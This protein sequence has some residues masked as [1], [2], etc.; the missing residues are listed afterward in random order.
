VGWF[1]EGVYLSMGIRESV[2]EDEEL[3]YRTIASTE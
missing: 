1:F 3:L 2:M